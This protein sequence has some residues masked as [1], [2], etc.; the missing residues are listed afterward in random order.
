MGGVPAEQE[1]TFAWMTTHYD[2]LAKRIPPEFMV[3][4]PYFAD[5][6]SLTRVDA[7]KTFFAEPAHAP[8]GTSKELARVAEAVGDCVVLDARE[9][10]SVRRYTTVVR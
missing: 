4:M 3:Y 8:P 1:K 2:E 9:G 5:G 10:E 6:C 7:A